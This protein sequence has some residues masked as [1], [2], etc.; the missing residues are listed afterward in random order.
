MLPRF[1][2]ETSIS[3]PV[4]VLADEEA[5]HLIH[6]LRFA[7]GDSIAL[8]DGQGGEFL[9]TI[10]QIGRREVRVQVGERQPV[11]RENQVQ[12]CIAV[13]LPKGDR[14]K[15]L[16]E[17]LTELGASELIP[18][19]TAR[20]VAQ[21]TENACQRLQRHVI[22]ASKQCGRNRLMHIG[23]P[24]GI[25][26]LLADATS[27]FAEIWIAHPE[28]AAEL[29]DRPHDDSGPELK[30]KPEAM[31]GSFASSSEVAAATDLNQEN[32]AA[33]RIQKN[34][35]RELFQ[36]STVSSVASLLDRPPLTDKTLTKP[37]LPQVTEPALPQVTVVAG[38]RGAAT[39]FNCAVLVLIGPEGGFTDDEYF[40]AMSR[41]VKR[42]DL[43][44]RI[45]RVET[46]AIA[47]LCRWA[48]S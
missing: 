15:T 26:E 37:A 8:F 11:E 6:V 40:L 28:Y 10:Q 17:K 34:D 38:E 21:P 7:V 4:V 20:G 32:V 19:L 44:P 35:D 3:P 31:P 43:G 42:L 13:S 41:G 1:F 39:G 47:A 27:R 25:S 9:G 48:Q 29:A 2:S 45:L 22:A 36:T 5:H 33:Y 12:V 14:Q 18:L 16:V 24:Q 23:Q 30:S 46:A